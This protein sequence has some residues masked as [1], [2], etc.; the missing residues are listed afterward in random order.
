[1][2]DLSKFKI[3]L[4]LEPPELVSADGLDPD[5]LKFRL[6]KPEAFQGLKS[7]K[8]AVILPGQTNYLEEIGYVV[9]L[10]GE[11][12][13]PGPYQYLIEENKKSF[14]NTIQAYIV[15]NGIIALFLSGVF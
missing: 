7:F 11:S 1:M 2:I 9:K 12:G 8:P 13:K 15:G 6:L 4:Q 3:E 14:E 5:I 10:N